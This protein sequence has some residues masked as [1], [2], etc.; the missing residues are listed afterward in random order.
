MAKKVPTAAFYL[1]DAT[2]YKT[3]SQLK[4]EIVKLHK[5]IAELMKYRD[6]HSN[7]LQTHFEAK[8]HELHKKLKS[9][10]AVTQEPLDPAEEKEQ[11]S[12][13]G[14]GLITDSFSEAECHQFD[15]ESDAHIQKI[16]ATAFDNFCASQKLSKG[17]LGG[18]TDDTTPQLPLPLKEPSTAPSDLEPVNTLAIVNHP[19]NSGESELPAQV[20]GEILDVDQL[21][22]FVAADNQG[23]ARQLLEE[24]QNHSDDLSF[25]ANDQVILNGA[26]LPNVSATK[27]FG[28]LYRPR[29]HHSD[30]IPIVDEIASL[31]LGHLIAR[32]YTRGLTPKGSNYLKNR[33]AIRQSLHPLHPWYYVPSDD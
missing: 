29:K 22:K 7:A 14:A 26:V 3:Y 30:I 10:S 20:S 33:A 2:E 8:L 24:L 5:H 28:E 1:I 6:L 9:H 25:A 18:G 12:Q 32:Y 11:A 31:G 4:E 19:T 17:Q 15:D 27:V 21:L 23:K 16:L 13:I